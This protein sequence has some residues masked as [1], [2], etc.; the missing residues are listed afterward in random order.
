MKK[1]SRLRTCPECGK[2]GIIRTVLKSGGQVNMC[3]YCH[4]FNTREG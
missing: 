3:R 1:G 2:R 4:Y